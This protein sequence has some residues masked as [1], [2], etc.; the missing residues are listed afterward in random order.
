MKILGGWGIELSWN[1]HGELAYPY[2]P[3]L[4]S[5]RLLKLWRSESIYLVINLDVRGCQLRLNFA[6]DYDFRAE[7][8]NGEGYYIASPNNSKLFGDSVPERKASA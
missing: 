2:K 6:P 5:S 4:E 7:V 8:V 3:C 1:E